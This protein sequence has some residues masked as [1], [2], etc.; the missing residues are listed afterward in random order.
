MCSDGREPGRVLQ[1]EEPIIKISES[2]SDFLVTLLLFDSV[3]DDA[4]VLGAVFFSVLR[5]WL[6]FFRTG[7]KNVCATVN[8]SICSDNFVI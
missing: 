7:H 5:L 3:T 1:V 2:Y 6:F 4:N 8:E